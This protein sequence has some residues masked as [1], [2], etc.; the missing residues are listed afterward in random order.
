MNSC[1][2][3][4]KKFSEFCKYH[5]LKNIKESI[6]SYGHKH[7]VTELEADLNNLYEEFITRFQ[8]VKIYFKQINRLYL[9]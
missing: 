2:K 1:L 9:Y 6:S 3:V 5:C 4:V 7:K 8:L